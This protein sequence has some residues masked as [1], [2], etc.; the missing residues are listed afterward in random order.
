M[1]IKRN[2]LLTITMN[3]LSITLYSS[4]SII[5]YKLLIGLNYYHL[6]ITIPLLL[7]LTTLIISSSLK[8]VLII[9]SMFFNYNK[10]EMLKYINGKISYI[11]DISIYILIGIFI[12]LLTSF[13]VLDII[14]CLRFSNYNLLI[15]SLAIWTLLYY[16]LLSFILKFM[17]KEI[18]F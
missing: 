6:F 2:K 1:D 18:R 9:I 14:L 15:I 3:I 16:Y 8:L 7:L 5:V 10:K 4:L 17:K 12:S 13:M 11:N